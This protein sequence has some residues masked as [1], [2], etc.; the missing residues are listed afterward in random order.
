VIEGGNVY[1]PNARDG[2]GIVS[3]AAAMEISNSTLE[4]E[5]DARAE[6][7]QK[8]VEAGLVPHLI[9]GR[10]EVPLHHFHRNFRAEL[11]LSPMAR[12]ND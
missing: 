11:G 4:R 2:N 7:T 12:V 3:P 8:N 1:D 5:D 6:A 10:N 9:F